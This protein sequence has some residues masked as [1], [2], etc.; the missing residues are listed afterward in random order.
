M[1]GAPPRVSVLVPFLD[2][3][4]HIEQCAAAILAQD[5]P[6][7][8]YEAIFIDN[9]SRDGSRDRVARY[10]RI[11]IVEE[12][13]RGSYAA[14]NRGVREAR[15]DLLL[16]T[17]ADCA[18]DRGWLR[19]HLDAL[20]AP[21]VDVVLGPR[22]P[23]RD[24]TALHLMMLYEETKAAVIFGGVDRARYYGYTNNMAVRRETLTACGGFDEVLRGAD[25]VFVR[26]VVDRNGPGA[27]RYR[28]EAAVTHLEIRRLGQW[29]AKHAIYG[30]SNQR[31]SRRTATC[32][33]L[34]LPMRWRT[35]RAA[36]REHG[37]DRAHAALLLAILVV[38]GVSHEVGRLVGRFGSV[39]EVRA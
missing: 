39:A 32:R 7:S 3:A 37:L 2:N 9:G 14:R 22:R 1:N 20:M 4:D 5:A 19:Q 18:P 28:R 10:P 24:G 16:F 36:V 31:N 13:R 12:A 30:R 25:S 29:Y 15:G 34:S 33:P 26:R 17:D 11:R 35:Y 6:E 21:G 27:V 23:A 38:G 8:L